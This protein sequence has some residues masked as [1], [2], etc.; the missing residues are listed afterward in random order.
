MTIK[1]SAQRSAPIGQQYNG[2]EKDSPIMRS[3]WQVSPCHFPD[4]SPSGGEQMSRT[5]WMCLVGDLNCCRLIRT[6]RSH[7]RHLENSSWFPDPE[8]YRL[9]FLVLVRQVYHMSPS[10][11]WSLTRR[12]TVSAV[13][14][15]SDA[16]SLPSCVLAP[17]PT[18]RYLHVIWPVLKTACLSLARDS[19]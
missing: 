6:H 10:A 4:S 19:R 13:P 1:L 11:N 12:I 16:P 9:M 18:Q 7:E 3:H 17:M 14:Y 8:K 5:H 15:S 2:V